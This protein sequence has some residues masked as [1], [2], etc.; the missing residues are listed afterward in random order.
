MTVEQP[1]P[2]EASETPEAAVSLDAPEAGAVASPAPAEAPHEHLFNEL[3]GVTVFDEAFREFYRE[4]CSV[5]GA[6]R[7]GRPRYG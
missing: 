7:Q 1:Q 3:S 2:P 6:F 5:C 4:M